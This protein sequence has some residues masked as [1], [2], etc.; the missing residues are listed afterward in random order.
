MSCSECKFMYCTSSV[1]S[2]LSS[3]LPLNKG[4]GKRWQQNK[5]ERMK[6]NLY[7]LVCCT[8]YSQ[9]SLTGSLQQLPEWAN[10]QRR[11]ELPYTKAVSSTANKEQALS[12]NTVTDT[13]KC[14][15]DFCLVIVLIYQVAMLP[16]A[17]FI[18]FSPSNATRFYL[19]QE[20]PCILL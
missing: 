20:D 6:I 12:V 3:H 2:G 11:H 10:G 13:L 1:M 16:S 18:L 14:M 8:L 17:S 9:Y 19:S 15:H 5:R 7:C 4:V